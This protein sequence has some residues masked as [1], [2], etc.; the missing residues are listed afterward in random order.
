VGRRIGSCARWI[1]GSAPTIFAHGVLAT[2]DMGLTAMLLLAIHSGWRWMEDPVW[3]RAAALGAATGL[4]VLSKFSTLA[5]FPSVA[6]VAVGIWLV[7]ER[8][9]IKELPAMVWKRLPQALVVL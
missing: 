3:W 6:A 1:S 4:A 2:K 7:M 9:R 5:F 8:R